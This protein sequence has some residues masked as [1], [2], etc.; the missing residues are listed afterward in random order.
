M[1][2]ALNESTYAELKRL[3]YLKTAF[4]NTYR[5]AVET[6]NQGL[7]DLNAA[8]Y[9][10][11]VDRFE[12][13]G[14]ILGDLEGRSIQQVGGMLEVANAALAELDLAAARSAFE[15]VLQ[16]ESANTAASDGLLMVSSLEGIAAEVH[17]LKVLQDVGELDEALVQLEALLVSIRITHFCSM[18]VKSSIRRF[19]SVSLRRLWRSRLRA[20]AEGD[21]TR[22]G[23]SVGSGDCD[24]PQSR[25]E[26]AAHWAQGEGESCALERCC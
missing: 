12:M 21:S 23:C 14:A 13:T 4:E 6:Y 10:E 22:C 7:R 24:S 8:N 9:K 15:K 18:S 17:G 2:R 11:S 3:E 26:R 1:A 5:E 25:V 20:E 16:I 19:G